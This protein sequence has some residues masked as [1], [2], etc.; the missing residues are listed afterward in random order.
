MI[1][2]PKAAQEILKMLGKLFV[3]R[4]LVQSLQVLVDLPFQ[5]GWDRILI[6]WQIFTLP[7]ALGHHDTRYSDVGMQ[8]ILR[9]SGNQ[10]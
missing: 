8:N 4:L 9:A 6:V 3:Q 2:F 5:F 10:T 1:L 7:V